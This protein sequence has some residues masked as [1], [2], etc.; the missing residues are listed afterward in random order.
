M[1]EAK[2]E[3][4][5][6]EFVGVFRTLVQQ[7]QEAMELLSRVKLSRQPAE[8][9][10]LWRAARKELLSHDRAEVKIVYA[11]LESRDSYEDIAEEHE[12]A[13]QSLETAVDRIDGMD[14]AAE[15]WELRIS[16]LID[17]VTAHVQDEERSYFPQAQ[18]ALGAHQADVLKSDYLRTQESEKE[19]V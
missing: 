3:Q 12:E 18:Q 11:A 2:Q 1:I 5:N 8:R 16:S 4:N 9:S 19:A 7:H 15:E 14:H 10:K 13:V 17:L 6:Q